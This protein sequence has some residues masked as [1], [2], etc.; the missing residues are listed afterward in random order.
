M[1]LSYLRGLESVPP[2]AWIDGMAE[3]KAHMAEEGCSMLV[4][5]TG[6]EKIKEIAQRLGATVDHRLVWRI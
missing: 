4:A 6:N 2:A 1:Y 3:L 5:T